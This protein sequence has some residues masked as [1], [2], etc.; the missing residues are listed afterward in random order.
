MN[1]LVLIITAAAL[2]WIGYATYGMV[3]SRWLN[4]RADAVTPA[5]EFRND[6]DF[7][8]TGSFYLLNQHLSAIAAAGP[9]VGPILAGMWFGWAPTFLWIVLGGIFIGGVHDLTTIV[10]SLRHQGKSI[11]EVIHATMSRKAFILFLFF[12]W[13]SLV[14]II[15]AF[16]DVTASTFI[17]PSR[18]A[19]IASASML[20]LLLALA[21]GLTLRKIKLPLWA[22]TVIFIPLVFVCIFLG[23]KFP[24]QLPSFLG[25]SPRMSW[26]VALL[27]Y[28]F[29]AAVMPV[30]LLLQPRGY[31]GGFFL[32]LTAGISVAG[33]VIGSFTQGYAIQYPAFVGWSNPQGLPLL[34]IL[35]TTVACGA[36]SGFHC[37]IASGTTSKQLSK[38]TDARLVG[39][40]GMLMESFVAVTSLCTLAILTTSQMKQ[41]QDPNQIYANGVATFLSALGINKEWALNFALLAFATFVYDTLDVA[42]RLGR[43]IFEELTGWKNTWNPYAATLATLLL[44]LFF[45]TR[46]FTDAQGHEI[47]GWKMFWTV[48]GASNQLLA[49]MVLFG[50]SVWLFKSRS[51]FQITLWPALFMIVVAVTSLVLIIRPWL[52]KMFTQRIWT[53]DPIGITGLVLLGLILLL[54]VEGLA[55]FRKGRIK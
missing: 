27:V 17:E 5:H 8:P 54:I 43:Y 42:T 52:V 1:I 14:Y 35:F 37:L 24:L 46:R 31:L 10:A 19:G 15:A 39:Y 49:G 45:L 38:E 26:N 2:L 36:C 4:L 29:F 22:S 13:F 9:I 3:L 28:C 33:I 40:G 47:P 48:F 16:T 50:L 20:Y 11:A 12:L 30:W 32:T 55:A 34:P 21:M 6:V 44:P 7:V 41:L 23:Q 18:G 25:L 51:K 53:A